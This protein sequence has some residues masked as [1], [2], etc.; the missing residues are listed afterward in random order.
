M[1]RPLDPSDPDVWSSLVAAAHPEMIL[2]LIG[3]RMGPELRARHS[4]EDLWQEALLKAWQARSTL[5]WQGMPAF[6]SWLVRIAGNCIE[7]H[8]DR[9]QAKKRTPIEPGSADSALGRDAAEPWAST[10]PSRIATARERANAMA[11]ALESLPEDLREVLR[12]R[13]FED[14]KI[15]AIATSLGIGESAVRHRF[16]RGAQLYRERLL[17]LLG[18]SECA[19]PRDG[20]A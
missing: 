7:D 20:T 12:L 17:A 18:E 16:R 6:R 4:P 11:K 13:I 8:R 14:A 3:Y 9:E 10:T 15:E 2:V 1:E 5:V 19:G